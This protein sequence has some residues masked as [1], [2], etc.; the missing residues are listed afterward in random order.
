M[1]KAKAKSVLITRSKGGTAERK[2]KLEDIKVPDLWQLYKW[3]R[4]GPEFRTKY[5][6][7]H[8]KDAEDVVECWMLAHDLLEHLRGKGR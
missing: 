4:L 6:R 8:A 2:V 1:G 7:S 5:K 3:L